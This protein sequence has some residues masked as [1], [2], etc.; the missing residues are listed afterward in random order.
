M[1]SLKYLFLPLSIIVSSCLESKDSF[2]FTSYSNSDDVTAYF[3]DYHAPLK[4]DKFYF[5][6][7][8]TLNGSFS[9]EI[10]DIRHPL[11]KSKVDLAIERFKTTGVLPTPDFILSDD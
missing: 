2:D 1:S 8:R 3:K 10:I 9:E 6:R 5:K 7:K 11:S 4:D